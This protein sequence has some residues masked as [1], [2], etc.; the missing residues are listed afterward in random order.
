[1]YKQNFIKLP[2]DEIVEKKA[3]NIKVLTAKYHGHDI[4]FKSMR[5]W[6]GLGP[7]PFNVDLTKFESFD[8]FKPAETEGDVAE[9][10]AKEM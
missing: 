8:D 9:P 3:R 6:V 7:N 5:K 10:P 2:G 4:S 1:M